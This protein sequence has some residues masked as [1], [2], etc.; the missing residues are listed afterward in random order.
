VRLHAY[1]DQYEAAFRVFCYENNTLWVSVEDSAKSSMIDIKFN[2][3]D[4]KK[5]V[6]VLSK[7]AE[8]QSPSGTHDQ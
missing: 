2:V 7:W 5:L 8:A 6:E 4:V 1:R 3:E